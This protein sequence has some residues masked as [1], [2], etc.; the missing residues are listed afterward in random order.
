MLPPCTHCHRGVYRFAVVPGARGPESA[1]SLT[2]HSV[3]WRVH[4]SVARSLH[5]ASL[6]ILLSWYGTVRK[7]GRRD[8]SRSRV[9][10]QHTALYFTYIGF[11]AALRYL[12]RLRLLPRL[13][14][15]IDPLPCLGTAL[16]EQVGRRDGP[17]AGDLGAAGNRVCDRRR[18]GSAGRSGRAVCGGVP[19]GGADYGSARFGRNGSLRR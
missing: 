5:E 1:K 7:V 10:V 12:G 4:T 19:S 18:G 16:T 2:V 8:A 9:S 15:L 14:G 6:A 13:A 11:R 3:S 17:R